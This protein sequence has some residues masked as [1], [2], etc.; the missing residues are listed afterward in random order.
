MFKS[1]LKVLSDRG[2]LQRSF[3]EKS[4]RACVVHTQGIIA[5]YAK[6]IRRPAGFGAGFL[7]IRLSDTKL[8]WTFVGSRVQRKTWQ[9]ATPEKI[10]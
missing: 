2:F 5:T 9:N 4:Q 6:L 3:Q 8:V 1:L 7:T 10:L